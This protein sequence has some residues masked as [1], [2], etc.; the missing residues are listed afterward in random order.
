MPIIIGTLIYFLLA[1]FLS[2]QITNNMS[3]ALQYA[4]LGFFAVVY[5]PIV[6]LL[7]SAIGQ[8]FTELTFGG[9]L[10]W[11]LIIVCTLI[12]LVYGFLFKPGS[13]SKGEFGKKGAA[14]FVVGSLAI[15]AVS[16]G[17]I[18]PILDILTYDQPAS[19][20]FAQNIIAGISNFVLTAV[21][22]TAL[23]FTYAKTR[24]EL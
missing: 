5:G 16:W 20:M 11:G 9:N 7:I 21:V 24:T 1:R 15:H 3:L 8:F 4:A 18:M 14:R 10:R 13:V 23:I 17:L 6:G 19:R 2:I 12:G 22:G